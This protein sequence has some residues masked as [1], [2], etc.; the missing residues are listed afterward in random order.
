MKTCKLM[1]EVDY[2]PDATDPES[3]ASMMDHLFKGIV[4]TFRI[5]EDYGNPVVNEFFVS[6]GDDEEEDE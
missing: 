4:D 2:D 5:T 3:L 6:D 1:V